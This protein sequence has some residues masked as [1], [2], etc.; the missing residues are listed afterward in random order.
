MTLPA[1]AARLLSAATFVLLLT[2]PCLLQAQGEKAPAPRPAAKGVSLAEEKG[3]FRILLDG[4]P[5]GSEEFEISSAGREW[6][7]RAT[8]HITPPGGP[9][10]HVQG[11]LRLTAD[12]TPTRYEWSTQGEKKASALVTFQGSVASVTLRLENSQPLE[13]L[14]S[15]DS[16]RIMIL[17]N[18][19]YHHYAILARLYDWSARG[20]QTFPVL[21]P[22]EMTP[23]SITVESRG[24]QSVEGRALELLRVRT[25][26]LEIDLYLDSARRLVQISVPSSK[27]LILR[28]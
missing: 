2:T 5:V 10:T 6:Q 21:I 24:P 8:T 16:A 22:Q 20:P 1:P 17:D 28:E 26:D 11:T 7:A 3:R 23:G 27:A 18:N 25:A 9:A 19:L 4:Q 12:G 13:Q 15:F 14:F